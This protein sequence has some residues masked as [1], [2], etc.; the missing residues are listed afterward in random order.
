[1]NWKPVERWV[2][3]YYEIV[4]S[5]T[6]RPSTRYESGY[7]RRLFSATPS[8][9]ILNVLAQRVWLYVSFYN[10]DGVA[11]VDLSAEGGLDER[12]SDQ[13]RAADNVR[14]PF[15]RLGDATKGDV[16]QVWRGWFEIYTSA[17]VYPDA[18]MGYLNQGMG[19]PASFWD[20]PIKL[21][22][23]PI[24]RD[25]LDFPRFKNRPSENILKK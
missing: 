7:E 14:I 20:R 2:A 3:S 24:L 18:W 12:T 19:D 5:E 25:D 8:L 15:Q 21:V 23:A 10:A 17:E 6:R 9:S 4:N 16:Y 11:Q 13:F 22:K 1:M